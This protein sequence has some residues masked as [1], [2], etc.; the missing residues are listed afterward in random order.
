MP[1]DALTQLG[2]GVVAAILLINTTLGWWTKWQ[3]AAR[4]KR[5]LPPPP[6]MLDPEPREDTV[7]VRIRELHEALIRRDAMGQPILFKLLEQLTRGQAE[8][9]H[10]IEKQTRVLERLLDKD[11][12]GGQ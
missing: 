2:I 9:L 12:K 5:S 4:K 11:S 7:A 1:T 10:C 8:T 6:R 3:E